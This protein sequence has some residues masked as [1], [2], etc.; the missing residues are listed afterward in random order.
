MLRGEELPEARAGNVFGFAAGKSTVTRSSFLF[1]SFFVVAI[2]SAARS[3][4]YL[5]SP[6]RWAV[7]LEVMGE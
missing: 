1:D 6:G 7:N 4:L 3:L 5:F 2:D